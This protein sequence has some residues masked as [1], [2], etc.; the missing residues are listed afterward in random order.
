MN[1]QSLIAEADR[2][3]AFY[4]ASAT[5][6]PPYPD[7]AA[8]EGLTAFEEP[9]PS[10]GR[11]DRET[12][13]LLD[14]VGSPATAVTTGP[15]YYGYVVGG[16]LPA[17]AA[18]ERLVL[19]W[20]QRASTH[21]SSPVAAVIE[22]QAGRWVLDALDLPRESAGSDSGRARPPARLPAFPPRGGRS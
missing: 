11:P 22:R 20:D 10:T 15:R 19:A 8:I 2:R 16:V 21:T 12:L 17:A 9:F 7:V 14:D 18:A 6:R 13:A 4:A 3:A 1:E 5:T